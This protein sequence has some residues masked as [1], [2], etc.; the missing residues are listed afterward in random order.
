MKKLLGAAFFFFLLPAA[1]LI[2]IP[3]LLA[4]L[5]FAHPHPNPIYFPLAILCWL[6][7]SSV[8]IA[9]IVTFWKHGQGTPA[10]NAPAEKLVQSGLFKISRNPMYLGAWIIL[11]GYVF[12]FQSVVFVLYVVLAGAFF[13]AIVVLFEE[14]RLLK[15]YGQAYLDYRR[16]TPRW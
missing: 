15:R 9:T 8:A 6:A 12:R 11:L 10:P 16:R 2:Y 1:I 5:G 14:P 13:H 7:G 4:Y 3:V